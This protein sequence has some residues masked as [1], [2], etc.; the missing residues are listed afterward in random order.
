VGK[1]ETEAAPQAANVF[2]V[3]RIA[4]LVELMKKHDLAEIDLKQEDRQIRLARAVPPAPQPPLMMPPAMG[5]W[6]MAAAP[7]AAAPPMAAPSQGGGSTADVAEV[8]EADEAHITVIKS[9]RVGTFYTKPHPDA[10]LFVKVGAHVS[11]DSVVCIVE[12]MKV[13]NEIQAEVT[14]QVVAVLAENEEAVE[15][16]RPLFKVDTSK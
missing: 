13:F 15:Y 4:Q 16:G 6:P 1:N 12:A 2:E 3:E 10:P 14:G 11:P 9:P 7:P 8:E 5:G